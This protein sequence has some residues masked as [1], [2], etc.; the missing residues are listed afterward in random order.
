LTKIQTHFQLQGPLDEALLPRISDAQAVYGI[1]RI[2]L[3]P[4]LDS[5]TVEYDATR[6]KMTDVEALLRRCGLNIK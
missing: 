3:A 4:S 2:S 5:L 1:E 6:L